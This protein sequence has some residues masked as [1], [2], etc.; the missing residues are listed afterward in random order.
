MDATADNLKSAACF[1]EVQ[2]QQHGVQITLAVIP[3]GIEVRGLA[4]Y[5]NK[6]GKLNSWVSWEAIADAKVDILRH[7]IRRTT[8]KL[9]ET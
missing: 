7:T 5:R 6:V 9:L 4:D 3:S 1:A 8:D 2:M